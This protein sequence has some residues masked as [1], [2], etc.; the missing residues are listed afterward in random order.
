MNKSLEEEVTEPEMRHALSSTQNGKSLGSD[1]FTKDFFKSFYDLL[2]DDL[3]L[4]VREY[5]REG[6][7]HGP[8]N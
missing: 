2:K 4:L 1:G 7:I 3:L 6:K 5:Q 8:L